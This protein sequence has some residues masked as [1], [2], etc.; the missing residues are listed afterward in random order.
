M[1]EC[2]NPYYLKHKE[3]F[4]LY[5][6][7][8]ASEIKSDKEVSDYLKE[9]MPEIYERFKSDV[10]T[11]RQPHNASKKDRATYL[12][13]AYRNYDKRKGY[14]CNLTENWIIRNILNEKCIYCGCE[15]YRQLG[16][17]RINNKVGHIKSN[18]VPCCLS[19]NNHRGKKEINE[20]LAI[21]KKWGYI[22]RTSELRLKVKLFMKKFFHTN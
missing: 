22:E 19:C 3:R 9:S 5:Q 1:L 2:M 18:V 7:R 16:A 10:E 17:D 8:K 21:C 6:K 20:W 14:T 13:R 4:R 11:N 15:D 12:Y